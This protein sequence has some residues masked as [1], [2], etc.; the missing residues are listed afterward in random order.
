M[1]PTGVTASSGVV[2]TSSMEGFLRR[3]RATVP[4]GTKLHVTSGVRDATSQASAM[5]TKYRL[6]GKEELYNLYR[7]DAVVRMLVSSSPD[8]TTWARVLAKRGAGISRHLAGGAFD[9]RDYGATNNAAVVVAVAK[10]GG[11]AFVETTP[12]HVHVDM[13]GGADALVVA[14]AVAK[15]VGWGLGVVAVVGIGIAVALRV[16]KR[17]GA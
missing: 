10:L 4:R 1:L 5:L 16:W 12:A 11:K 7:D 9:L 17:R 3:L 2:L 6:G 13:P 15:P 14:Q 8:V